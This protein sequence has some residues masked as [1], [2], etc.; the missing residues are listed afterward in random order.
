MG[1]END[2]CNAACLT[3]A[4]EKVRVLHQTRK[5]RALK[6]LSRCGPALEI[7]QEA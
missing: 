6:P 2:A 3:A 4:Q 7:P 5:Q 1:V